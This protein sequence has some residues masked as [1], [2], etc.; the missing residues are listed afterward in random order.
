M[1]ASGI[2]RASFLL[3]VVRSSSRSRKGEGVFSEVAPWQ[4]V[5]AAGRRPARLD[6]I[7]EEDHSGITVHEAASAGFQAGA[8][9]AM[10]SSSSSA[11]STT[12]SSSS[13][14]AAAYRFAPPPAAGAPKTTSKRQ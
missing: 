11:A 6:T 2:Q 4:P 14:A 9:A 12:A 8:A 13:S 5:A 10:A 3:Q 7:V 1:M